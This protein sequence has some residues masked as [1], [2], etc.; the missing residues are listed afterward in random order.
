MGDQ[1]AITH[2]LAVDDPVKLAADF[3]FDEHDRRF[4]DN[5]IRGIETHLVN[6][7]IRGILGTWTV[8]D[9]GSAP[10]STGDWVCLASLTDD[11]RRVTR[12]TAAALAKAG[13]GYGIALNNAAPGS[14]LMVAVM[15]GIPRTLT[16]LT[17]GLATGFARINLSTAR[18]EYVATPSGG[19]YI[20]G[21][22]D[23][24]GNVTL[25]R[26]PVATGDPLEGAATGNVTGLYSGPLYVVK[27]ADTTITTPAGSFLAGQPFI[28]G[29]PTH[30]GFG[31]L[32]FANEDAVTGI[33]AG[34]HLPAAFVPQYVA[35][36]PDLQALDT[37]GFFDC[38]PCTVQ[39]T[40]E[41]YRV[42]RSNT[43]T[44]DLVGYTVI[45][46]KQGG[47]TNGNWIRDSL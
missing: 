38:T 35:T 2:D 41:I 9:G 6:L 18:T 19:D 29:D 45:N 44:Q 31:K 15:G 14:G 39:E 24:Q 37:T 27:I 46:A 1:S 43:D 40:R 4:I 3:R 21:V 26:L 10:I 22:V 47:G 36:I 16:G 7:L 12:A 20:V 33:I 25:T 28:A 30:A 5:Q 11:G 8:L 32:D 17:S 34:S 23:T 42:S 13:A